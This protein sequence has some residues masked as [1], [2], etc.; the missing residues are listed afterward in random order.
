M[1]AKSTLVEDLLSQTAWLQRL[2]RGL[3][4]DQNLAD[5]LVQTS[6][7]AALVAPPQERGEGL[8]A[9]LRRVLVNRLRREH[10]DS[11]AQ[12]RLQRNLASSR[13]APAPSTLVARTEIQGA[14]IQALRTLEEPCRTTILR[15][16]YDDRSA[17]EIAMEEGIPES[18]VRNRLRRGLRRLRERLRTQY[19]N[20]DA[21]WLSAIAVLALPNAKQAISWGLLLRLGKMPKLSLIGVPILGLVLLL[22]GALLIPLDGPPTPSDLPVVSR[23]TIPEAPNFR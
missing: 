11:K 1:M 6:L 12:E 19:G 15:R 18:T 13:E 3:V 4:R 14:L 9:W 10:R 21:Q 23:R 20:D 16:Y 22:L 5:D 8:R 17:V 2:A 7:S